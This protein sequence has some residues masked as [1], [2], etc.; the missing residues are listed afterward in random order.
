M[1]VWVVY[2]VALTG[3]RRVKPRATRRLRGSWLILRGRLALSVDFRRCSA[4][5][6]RIAALETRPMRR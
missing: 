1:G 4:R 3:T 2:R 6:K 5:G